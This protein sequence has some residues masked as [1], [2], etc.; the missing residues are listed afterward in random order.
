MLRLGASKKTT[1]FSKRLINHRVINLIIIKR[2]KFKNK[3]TSID[4]IIFNENL[5]ENEK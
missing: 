1:L 3:K 4:V 5:I 2:S